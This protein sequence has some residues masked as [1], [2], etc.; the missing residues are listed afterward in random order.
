MIQQTKKIVMI[1]ILVVALLI[2]SRVLMVRSSLLDRLAVCAAYPLLLVQDAVIAPVAAWRE[3]KAI[4]Q[5][6]VG[7]VRQYKQEASDLRAEN[8]ALKGTQVHAAETAELVN[9]LQRYQKADKLIAQIVLKHFSPTEH[10]FLLDAGLN[11]GVKMD[12]IAVYENCLLGRVTEVHPSYAKVTLV[13]DELSKIPVLCMNTRSHGI[14]EGT[15]NVNETRL[16][17]VSH[18]QQLM[19]GDLLL[20]SGDGLIYP[21]GFAVGTIES[22]RLNE[23]GLS[24]VVAVK[25]LVDFSAIKY[26]CLLEKGQE[27]MGAPLSPLLA[28]QSNEPQA[29]AGAP[30]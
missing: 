17:F 4:V 25:P 24:Y 6:L 15:H 20:T 18:L 3:R 30:A 13:T 12:M 21:Q 14:H 29:D 16:A 11:R 23:L 5:D 28:A 26:C 2:L 9:F 8:L 27:A 7:L 1:V 19:P 22:F 10:F